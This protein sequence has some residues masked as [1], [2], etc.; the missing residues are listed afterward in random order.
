MNN[1]DIDSGPASIHAF[2][3]MAAMAESYAEK[4]HRAVRTLRKPKGIFDNALAFDT[5]LLK[6]ALFR[7]GTGTREVYATRAPVPAHGT[8]KV[9]FTGEEL[10]Q[11]DQRVLLMLVKSRFGKP[12]ND[13]IEFVPRTF[14]RDVLQWPDS[15]GSVKKLR[16]CIKR[17]KRASVDVEYF[18]GGEGSYSF[19][20]DYEIEKRKNCW[21]I[22]LSSRLVDMFERARTTFIDEGKRLG[23]GDNFASWLYT[24][25]K[26]DAC[27]APIETAHL[28]AWSGLDSYEQKNFNRKLRAELEKLQAEGVV[29]RFEIKGARL[30]LRKG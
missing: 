14:V 10:R 22:W 24:F 2:N 28:R 9:Y 19:V 18:G 6:S 3:A 26:A 23:L 15:G 5:A 29:A 1:V 11:D 12:V 30:T 25:I 7:A 21:S 20:T 8:T 16:S 27:F 4:Q 13:V 17:L